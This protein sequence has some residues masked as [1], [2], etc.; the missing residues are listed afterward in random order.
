MSYMTQYFILYHF[1]LDKNNSAIK[2]SQIATYFDEN[3]PQIEARFDKASHSGT[4]YRIADRPR[5]W[6]GRFQDGKSRAQA[7]LFWRLP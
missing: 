1:T 6:R 5:R 7:R 2:I 4:H 3:A